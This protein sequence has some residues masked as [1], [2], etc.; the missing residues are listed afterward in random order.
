MEI[1]LWLDI[2]VRHG[3]GGRHPCC[4]VRDPG[5]NGSLGALSLVPRHDVD[6]EIEDLGARDGGGDVGFLQRAALVLL[7]V[8]PAAV[9]ELEDEHLAGAGEDDGR[10]GGDHAD[11]LVGLHDLL[12]AGE[13]Q[14]VVL[15]VGGGLDLA[16]LLRPEQLELLLRRG[17]LLVRLLL[18]RGGRVRDSAGRGVRGSRRVSAVRGRRRVRDGRAYDARGSEAWAGLGEQGGGEADS[19][20]SSMLVAWREEWRRERM[21]LCLGEAP[22]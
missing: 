21:Q 10:L 7:G 1:L 22:R 4:R 17:A 2:V 12:D 9:G 16:V 11:V 14:V 20:V 15:E 8:R 19:M 18:R 5:P 6:E 3:V 13:R